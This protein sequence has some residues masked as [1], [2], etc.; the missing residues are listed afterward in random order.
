MATNNY[1]G[2]FQ[3][4]NE[5]N[6]IEDLIVESIRIH[7]IDNW[8]MPR[9]IVAEDDLLNEDDLSTFNSAYMMEMYIKNVDGFEGEGDF[10]SKFGIQIKDAITFTVAVRTF[11]GEIGEHTK[12]V[13]P[14]EGDLIYLPLNGKIFE[15]MHVEHEAIFYQMGKLQTY[16]L[17]CELFEFSNERFYTGLDFID[18][19]FKDRVTTFDDADQSFVV[20]VGPNTSDENSL[21][22]Y[23]D[24]KE[25]PVLELTTDKRYI[26]DIGDST[27]SGTTFN[28]NENES[29]DNIITPEGI[30]VI[31]VPGVAGAKVIFT[32]NK[33][34]SVYYT[35]DTQV[36]MGNSIEVEWSPLSNL[37]IFDPGADNFAIEKEGDLIIDFTENNPYGEE[38]F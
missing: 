10:L 36:G 32:P 12:Q 5:Q 25:M 19:V 33:K 29:I 21:S 16:D 26:F 22:Y 24:G 38:N 35:S 7:G 23:I 14:N 20:T 34:D 1:F 18:N 37:D 6:L 31:G 2:N 15:V 13:R 8:Y 3:A 4:S 27:N 17:R 11:D 28:I 9:T 30:E